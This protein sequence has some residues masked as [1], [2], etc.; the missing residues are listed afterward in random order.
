MGED[1]SVLQMGGLAGLLAVVLYIVG[2]GLVIS[3]GGPATAEETLV[4]IQEL[5]AVFVLLTVV[6]IIGSLLMVALFLALHGFLRNAGPARALLGGAFGI[7]GALVLAANYAIGLTAF[8]VLS[9]LH[10]AAPAAEQTIIVIAAEVV[11]QITHAF[12]FLGILLI[13]LAFASFGWGLLAHQEVS[14][15]YGWA[16]VVFGVIAAV[17]ALMAFVFAGADVSTISSSIGFLA[18]I[19]LFLFLGW[20]IYR[21]A[22]AA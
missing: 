3:F 9:D 1:K 17:S 2:V 13:G 5:R 21:M 22:R 6:A 10:A 12:Q 11:E 18:I 15:G 20:K 14:K 16:S 4:R 8:P 7:S 19:A